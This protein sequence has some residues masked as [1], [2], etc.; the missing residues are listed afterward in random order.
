MAKLLGNLLLLFSWPLTALWRGYVITVLWAWFVVPAIGMRKI[1]IYEAV[2]AVIIVAAITPWHVPP[3]DKRE[4]GEE[5]FIRFGLVT[6]GPALI[7]LMGW[8][9]KT[10][11]W[12]IA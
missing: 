12:G 5:L 11:Q 10:L 3:E 8:I 2:A 6:V 1:S 7:L 9:W 4:A